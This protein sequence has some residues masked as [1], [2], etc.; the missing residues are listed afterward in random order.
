M[1][2]V[3]L[4]HPLADQEPQPDIERHGRIP[5]KLVEPSH[6]VEIALLDDV[7]GVDAPPKPG[8]QPQRHHPAEPGA[9]AVEQLDDGRAVARGGAGDKS[10]DLF[11]W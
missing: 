11:G 5:D 4:L 9:V 7:G 1:P 2:P 8:V 3:L 10:G 6:R